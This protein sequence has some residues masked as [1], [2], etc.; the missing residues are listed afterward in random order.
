MGAPVVGCVPISRA[1]VSRRTGARLT[2]RTF[3]SRP[4]GAHSLT[5][6]PLPDL[7]YA[8]AGG[9]AGGTSGGT[10]ERAREWE[11][12]GWPRSRRLVHSCA[13]RRMSADGIRSRRHSVERPAVRDELDP[14][15]RNAVAPNDRG[16]ARRSQRTHGCADSDE[17][18]SAESRP[19][20][21][22][23]VRGRSVEDALNRRDDASLDQALHALCRH[24]DES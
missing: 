22:P 2:S 12:W 16:I 6:R 18:V 14:S 15:G 11:G 8:P 3:C 9:V 4:H 10:V 23:S 13:W 5:T 20:R 17:P 19:S 7:A 24:D 1:D 21:R